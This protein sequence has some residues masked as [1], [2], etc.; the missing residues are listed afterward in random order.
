[1]HQ[2]RLRPKFQGYAVKPVMKDH[3]MGP[4]KVVLLDRWSFI[5]GTNV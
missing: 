1:M 5:T 4:Q 2:K 3:L